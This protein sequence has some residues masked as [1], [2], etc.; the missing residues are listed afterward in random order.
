M[1]KSLLIQQLI[2]QHIRSEKVLRAIEKIPREI[3]VPDVLKED[4]YLNTPLPIG[5]AQTI[6]QPYIVARM[7]ELLLTANMKK[8][9]EI[10]T[11][12]GYQ[13][14][15][16]SQIVD[17]VYSV[18][19]IL[20]LLEQSRERFKQ[21]NL[22]NIHTLYSDG[23]LGWP[24]HAPYDGIIVTAATPLVPPAL[25]EQ[26]ADGGR[27]LLPLGDPGLQ[28]QRL[29]LITRQGKRFTEESFDYVMFVPLLSGR[30]TE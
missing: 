29:Q 13:A 17:E 21:L 4:A 28:G 7:T 14:A 6:S 12:S 3:F 23:N 2:S 27:L 16:L 15:V 19:R 24:E 9:L 30:T 10:G 25:L 18:E 1:K 11:G 8:V 26:L 20:P 5:H 22:S